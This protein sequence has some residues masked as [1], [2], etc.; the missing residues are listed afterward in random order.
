MLSTIQIHVHTKKNFPNKS[1]MFKVFSLLFGIQIKHFNFY[2]VSGLLS[3]VLLLNNNVLYFYTP[4]VAVTKC[5]IIT[6]HT[7]CYH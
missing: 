6:V 2:K 7:C 5:Y 3:I 4:K 1:I